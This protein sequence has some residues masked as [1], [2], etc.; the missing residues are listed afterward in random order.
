[1]APGRPILYPDQVGLLVF[2]LLAI[3]AGAFFA[4]RAAFG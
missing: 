3:G 4:L 1:M 2:T